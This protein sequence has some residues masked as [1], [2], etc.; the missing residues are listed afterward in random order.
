MGIILMTVRQRLFDTKCES[1]NEYEDEDENEENTYQ[2]YG[3]VAVQSRF[4]ALSDINDSETVNDFGFG[5]AIGRGRGKRQRQQ[6]SPGD[7]FQH[8]PLKQRNIFDKSKQR[9]SQCGTHNKSASKETVSDGDE[10][11][12]GCY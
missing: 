4:D 2:E 8:P 3:D 5:R 6:S 12:K 11:D 10:W 1:K 7:N 9:P